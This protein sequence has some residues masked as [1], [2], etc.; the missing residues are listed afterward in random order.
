ML[1]VGWFFGEQFNPQDKFIHYTMG[2]N[3]VLVF[4]DW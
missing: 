3:H 4:K 2:Q 1:L